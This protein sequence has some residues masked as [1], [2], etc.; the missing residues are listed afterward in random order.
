MKAIK[1]Q[2]NKVRYAMIKLPKR[3][4]HNDVYICSFVVSELC[5]TLANFLHSAHTTIKIE[6]FRN[7]KLCLAVSVFVFVHQIISISRKNDNFLLKRFLF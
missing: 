1:N 2:L 4:C 7:S 5:H 6:L 3:M